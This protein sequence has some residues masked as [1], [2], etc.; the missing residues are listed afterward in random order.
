[1]KTKN[2]THLISLCSSCNNKRN[3]YQAS[4]FRAWLKYKSDNIFAAGPIVIISILALI[5]ICLILIFSSLYLWSGET[6]T[7][8]QS[9]WETFMRTMDPGSAAEDTGGIHRLISATVTMCGIF[10]ISTLIGALTTG[11]EGKLAEL[12]KGRTKVVE[13]NH[14]I[15]LGWSSKI[16][17]IINE[18]VIANENQHNPSIVILAP[19]DRIEMQEIISQKIDGN[20]NTKIICRNGDPMSIH[21]LNILS[22]NNARSII[23]LAPL[24]DNPDV[25]VIKTIL[26]IT[27]NPQRTKLKFHIVAEIKERNNIEVARIA[28]ADEVVFVHADEII[29]RIIAQSGRQSGLSIILSMLL[30][31]KYDEIYFKYEPLLVGKTFN[32]A[33]FLYRTSSVIGLMF[34]DETIKIC[35]SGDTI[36]HQ[37]DQIIV[38]AEDDDAINLSSNYSSITILYEKDI[39][40]ITMYNE[41]Q[42]NIEKNIILGW[43]SKASLIAKQLDNYVSEG[44][45]LHILTNIDKA[46]KIITE[47]LVNELKRQKLYLHSG[48]ITNRLDL[49]KLNLYNYHDVILLANDI[50]NEQN[51]LETSSSEAADAECLICLLHLRNMI[52]KNPRQKTFN[53]VT[54]MFDIRN[55][56]LAEITRADDFIVS[57]N[58]LSKYIAQISENKNL[59]KVFDVLLTAEGVEIYLRPISLFTKLDVAIPFRRI[60]EASLKQQTL[61]IGY[62]QMKYAQDSNKF[63]GI[64]LNPD[65][66]VPIIFQYDDKIIVLAEE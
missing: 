58:I 55:R 26:A 13:T 3:L 7:Y 39:S 56:E 65:K 45:E 34:A 17:D 37:N 63:Y 12:R 16:F 62:R 47:Q 40:S 64:V 19:I 1:M 35:P 22:P 18:L 60:L 52:D 33:L 6:N 44:S 24:N 20:K 8:S 51:Q 11:M 9:L 61:A 38:I 59:T 46:K 36:I 5:S 49:E 25:S 42:T 54:E 10:I 27:N 48:D 41:K 53:I 50:N 21:D 31:F 57:P 66:D 15:I 32:D 14:T 43:N 29:A 4:Y 30:S 2:K 28:G 23:I